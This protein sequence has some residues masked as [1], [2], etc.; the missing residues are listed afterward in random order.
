MVLRHVQV[1]E[2]GVVQ[3]LG[4]VIL[5]Q[6]RSWLQTHKLDSYKFPKGAKSPLLLIRYEYTET[7]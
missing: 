2:E 6:V 4:S 5:Q 1:I 7:Q 3:D